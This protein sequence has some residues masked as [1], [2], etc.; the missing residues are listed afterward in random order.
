[1]NLTLPFEVLKYT[2]AGFNYPTKTFCVLIP[3]IEQA[4]ARECLGKELFDFLVSHLEPYPSVFEEWD[5][6]VTYALNDIVIRNLCTYKSTANGNTT[7]PLESGA[8]WDIFERFDHAGSNELWEKYLR[9]IFAAKVY[10]ATISGATYQ[11]GA[12]G[13]TVNAGDSSGAR[14]ANK[15]ELI[16]TIKE[17]NNFIRL[18]TDNMLCWLSDNATTK[19]LPY[20]PCVAGCEA[21]TVRSRRWAFR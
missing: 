2:P 4:F 3:Q 8:D 10:V 5:S 14:A 21:T 1:M 7:D 18:T 15:M 17:Q 12:G 9:Q 13:L 16:E 20:V 19:G 6:A 11:T